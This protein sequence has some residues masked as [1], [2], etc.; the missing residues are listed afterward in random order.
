MRPILP[1]FREYVCAHSSEHSI[2]Q[3]VSVGVSNP[4]YG[5]D[6][7]NVFN[8]PEDTGTD[9][10]LP[11]TETSN[12]KMQPATAHSIYCCNLIHHEVRPWVPLLSTCTRSYSSKQQAAHYHC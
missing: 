11:G 10:Y 9:A 3:S 4:C 6:P 7:E 12:H 1:I 2:L 5:I 8:L